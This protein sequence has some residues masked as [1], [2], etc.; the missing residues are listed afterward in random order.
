ML[1]SPLCP[2]GILPRVEDGYSADEDE[3]EPQTKIRRLGNCDEAAHSVHS[4]AGSFFEVS[5]TDVVI[6]QAA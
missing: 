5:Y 2:Q 1:T 3:R 4:D 6:G